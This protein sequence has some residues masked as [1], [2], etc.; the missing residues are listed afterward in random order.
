[1]SSL[2]SRDAFSKIFLVI[3]QLDH[4]ISAKLSFCYDERHEE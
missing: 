4:A 3:N 2:F 1:M